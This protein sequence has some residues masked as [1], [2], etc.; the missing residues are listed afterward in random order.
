MFYMTK[1]EKA[2]ALRRTFRGIAPEARRQQRRDRLIEAGVEVFGTRGFHAV[3]VREVCA[4]AQLTERYFY[5]SF[6]SLEDLFTA[7]YG[8]VNLELRQATLEALATPT[9]DP[10]VLAE[11]ALRVL[12]NYVRDDPRRGRIMLIE[13]VNVG[14]DVNRM[15]NEITRDYTEL[16]RGFISTLFPSMELVGLKPDLISVGLVGANV[17]IATTW[18]QEGFRTPLEDVLFNILAIYRAMAAQFGCR[19]SAIPEP[20]AQKTR[21][22]APAAKRRRTRK[23]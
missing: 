6:R 22:K 5:E 13:S 18:V 10:L 14:Q 3:T 15:T 19:G 8:C 9:N 1:H 21:S 11:A 12:F 23:A 4:A 17:R 7:V 16:V 2:P 20:G